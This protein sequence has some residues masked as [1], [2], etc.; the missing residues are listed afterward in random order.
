MNRKPALAMLILFALVG[1]AHA[2]NALIDWDF[3]PTADPPWL[4]L[5]LTQ[6]NPHSGDYCVNLTDND[7]GLSFQP[8]PAHR[9]VEATFWL[10]HEIV[11]PASIF[12]GYSVNMEG[13]D[14]SP[15]VGAVPLHAYHT[16][17]WRYDWA[18][19]TQRDFVIRGLDIYSVGGP[20]SFVDDVRLVL[21]GRQV[22][23]DV[24]PREPSNTIDLRGKGLLPVAILGSETFDVRDVDPASLEFEGGIP[25]Q[26]GK[27][28]K[29]GTFQ[30]INKDSF[31]DL[32]VRFGLADLDLES[33][34]KHV[35][36]A[37]RLM[38]G[39]EFFGM[40][41]ITIS[42]Q[43]SSASGEGMPQVI[44]EPAVLSMLAI[45]A[46]LPLLRKRK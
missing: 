3:E 6:A 2:Q 40:D 17:W 35:E 22:S 16:D 18:Y 45:G 12:A 1:H 26:R 9:V 14:G 32:V 27:S 13:K 29:V 39:T 30:D 38:D 42:G 37:G 20:A 4:G 36:L 8:I 19:P 33:S 23:V 46:C 34:T 44:P 31:P 10:R 28:G 21:D 5:V 43:G 11:D 15:M 41:I 7:I 25:K 24:M